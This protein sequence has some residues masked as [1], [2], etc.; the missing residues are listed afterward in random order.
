MSAALPCDGFE[1]GGDLVAQ[2]VQHSPADML[3][4]IMM[5]HLQDMWAEKLRPR[6]KTKNYLC[7]QCGVRH[8]GMSQLK[9]HFR[10]HTGERKGLNRHY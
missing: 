1:R 8:Q 9:A 4:E 5:L 6:R 10:I 3:H 2:P 7:E